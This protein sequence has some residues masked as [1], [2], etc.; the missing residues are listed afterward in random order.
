MRTDNE[1]NFFH[2]SKSSKE[3]DIGYGYQ[4][5]VI[6]TV[7]G[8][9]FA[10]NGENSLRFSVHGNNRKYKLFYLPVPVAITSDSLYPIFGFES[11]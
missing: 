9:Q 1:H 5:T 11:G 7:D 8:S 10:V 6:K 2:T 3:A 4:L